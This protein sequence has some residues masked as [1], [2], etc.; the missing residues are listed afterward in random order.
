MLPKTLISGA[1]WG[2]TRQLL[3]Q[4]Y[5]VELLIASHDPTQWN[6]S[7]ST[8]LSEVM[9]IARKLENGE[10]RDTRSV[11]AL[12]LWRNPQ[13]AV[14]SLAIIRA[15]LHFDPSDIATGHGTTSL[16]IGEQKIGESV[17]FLWSDLRERESW[18]LA[19]A[20]AQTELVRATYH[21]L[22]GK[23]KLPGYSQTTS[24]PLIAL[25]KLGKLG[26]DRRDIYDGFEKVNEKTVFPAF[27]GHDSN[28]VQTLAQTNNLHLAALSQAKN[29]RP[30]RR[31]EQLWPL[32]GRL[33][34]AERLRLS[35]Q[36]VSAIRLSKPAL[37]NVWWSFVFNSD[38]S[39][40]AEKA[41]VLW[42]NSTLGLMI[43]FANRDETE[44]AWVSFKKPTLRALPVLDILSLSAIQIETLAT[45][46]DQLCHDLLQP[47]SQM[48]NDPVRTEIDATIIQVLNLPDFNVFKELLA[49]EPV[50]C[51]KQ[52]P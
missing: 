12:N 43:L 29:G 52:L 18:M 2:K 32:A 38:I 9:L 31:P 8:S 25:E 14:E 11:V 49:Q 33:L 42:L 45:A 16:K 48:E 47:F 34:L 7:E 44:G 15:F 37:S 10:N 40:E 41:L 4:K 26:P 20:F 21:L 3:R 36:R 46:Y 35:T 13:T 17:S 27:W 51:L 24:L 39:V 19:C 50:I 1:A 22:N 6:F 5:Q 28:T 30:L 23:L